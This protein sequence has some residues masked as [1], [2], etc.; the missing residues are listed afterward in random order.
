MD[1]GGG[2]RRIGFLHTLGR[3][4][5]SRRCDSELLVLIRGRAAGP[6][7]GGTGTLMFPISGDPE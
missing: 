1:H 2:A 4:M 6:S 7:G 5:K 3:G